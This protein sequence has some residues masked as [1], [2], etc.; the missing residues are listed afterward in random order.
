MAWDYGRS[1]AGIAG[2]N[3]AR[4]LGCLSV[5]SVVFCQVE[6][7]ATGRSLVQMN[8]TECGVSECDR[9]SRQRGGSGPLGS[10]AK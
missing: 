5:V 3:S 4:E 6:V 2:S 10:G 9:D 8:P 1:L 7:S